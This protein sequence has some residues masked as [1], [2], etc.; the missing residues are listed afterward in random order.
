[1]SFICVNLDGFIAAI[2][3]CDNEMLLRFRLIPGILP[4]VLIQ[5]QP[6]SWTLVR[7]SKLHFIIIKFHHWASHYWIWSPRSIIPETHLPFNKPSLL[8]IQNPTFQKN[9]CLMHDRKGILLSA[10]HSFALPP[11]FL[12]SKGCHHQSNQGGSEPELS[13][14]FF[15]KFSKSNPYPQLLK[16]SWSQEMTPLAYVMSILLFM[17]Q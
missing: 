4:A 15:L 13:I 6:C 9:I 11:A 5:L 12:Q 17:L 1:M 7:L 16:G 2:L 8:S 3:L 10:G 14:A